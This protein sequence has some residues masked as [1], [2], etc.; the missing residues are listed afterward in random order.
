MSI[1]EKKLDSALFCPR[2]GS[3]AVSYSTLVGGPASCDGCAW[4]GTT[5]KLLSVPIDHDLGN[6]EQMLHALMAD[7]RK[8]IS[9][10]LGIPYL[11]LLVKWGFVSADMQH[12][13]ET[14]DRKA[15]SRYLAAIAGAILKA[16]L[17]TRKEI[18]IEKVKE[19]AAHDNPS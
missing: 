3:A 9:G 5:E 1:P 15:F 7:I 11:E 6:S 18:E 17:E 19:R 2:C 12:I 16:L 14:L 8:R 10:T 4:R 13:A